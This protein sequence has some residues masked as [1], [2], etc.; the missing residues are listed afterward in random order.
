MIED[1]VKAFGEENPV[2]EIAL[3]DATIFFSV[4]FKYSDKIM[5][6]TKK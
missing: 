4:V 1:K 5:K 2:A 6:A 3:S